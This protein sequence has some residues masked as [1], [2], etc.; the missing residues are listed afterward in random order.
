MKV[1]TIPAYIASWTDAYFHQSAYDVPV[2]YPS[3]RVIRQL[4]K[5]SKNNE[6]IKLYRGINNYNKNNSNLT[7]WT[8][9]KKVAQR[10]IMETGGTVVEKTFTKEQILLDT[11]KLTKKE[12]LQLGYDYKIDDKE[13]LILNNQ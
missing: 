8:Y 9:D 5:I 6:D 11:N 10:Y 2:R 13:V 1:E 3:K 12:K 4:K 7:S